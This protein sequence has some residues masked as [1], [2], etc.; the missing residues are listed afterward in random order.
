MPDSQGT[1]DVH[2]IVNA[3]PAVAWSAR[4][5][6]SA[7]FFN[8]HYLDYAGLS[9]EQALGWGWTAAVHPDDLAG[10][11]ATWQALMA[12]GQAG[13]AEARLRRADGDYRWFLFR[14]SPLRDEEGKIVKWYGINTD[15]EDRKRADLQLAGEKHLL[16]MIASGAPL[17]EVLNATC[18]FVE[19]VTAGCQCA[20]YPIDWSGPSFTCGVAPSLPASYTDPIEGM[21]HGLRAVWSTPICSRER[22]LVLGTFCIYHGKPATPSQPQQELIAHVTHIASI[23]IE[24]WQAEAALRRSETLLEE[25]QRL[26][27]TG[28]LSWWTDT[29]E[30]LFSE[31]L[32]RIFE[33]DPRGAVTLQGFLAR[34][35]PEDVLLVSGKMQLARDGR[36]D[37]D[38][39]QFRLMMPGGK[40]KYVRVVAH[41]IRHPSGRVE[42]LGAIQDVTAGRLADDALDRARSELGHVTRVMS[43]GTM[44]ASIAHEVN[45]PLSGII[46]NASTCLRMLAAETPDLEGARETARR[47]IRDGTRAAEVITR[48]RALFTKKAS[49]TEPVDLNEATRE[50][51]ALTSSELL[52]NRTLLRLELADGLPPIMGDRVQ[53]QQVIMNLLRNASEAMVGIDDRPRQ[54]VIKTGQESGDLVTLTVRDAGAGLECGIDKLFEAFH[55]T[56]VDGM[57][58]GL[59]LS[60]SIVERHQGRLWAAPNDGPGVTFALSLPYRTPTSKMSSTS[61]GTPSGRLSTP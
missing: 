11:V 54:A 29:D 8:Q 15:I 44:T 36:G 56:K 57:G 30:L 37:L 52:R 16:E 58:I 35:H 27:Q 17:R 25:G 3:I 24:R 5:D 55:T 7:D 46:T 6:G 1:V 59:S 48:L 53:L 22:R 10:L 33:L 40:V 28:S 50:V 19:S 18:K 12:S 9:A 49:T 2:Q 21:P 61:T 14:A 13:E 39:Y 4:L 34:V 60:R 26:S 42:R 31:E 41:S 47:T 38:N 45:Q 32:H 20:I 43:L 51:V 23:A